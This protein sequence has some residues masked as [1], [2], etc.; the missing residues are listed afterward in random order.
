[1][2]IMYGCHFA[3]TLSNNYR[4]VLNVI[5]HIKIREI[6]TPILH[7]SYKTTCGENEDIIWLSEWPGMHKGCIV[8]KNWNM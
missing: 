6:Q 1:M 2:I 8:R 7:I 5:D 4:I 3:Y